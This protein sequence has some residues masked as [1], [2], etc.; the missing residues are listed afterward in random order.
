[1]KNKILRITLLLT[2]ILTCFLNS[3]FTQTNS[4]NTLNNQTE[5][6]KQEIKQHLTHIV[7]SYIHK[8]APKS[9]VNGKTIVNT[10]LD[11][12]VDIK[13]V[14]AQGH[15]ESHFGTTGVA[16]KT[17]NIFNVGAESK[18]PIKKMA[19]NGYIYK[20]PDESVEPFI[21]LLK[22]NYLV[23]GKTEE[24]LLKNYVNRSG[25]RYASSRSYESKLRSIVNNLKKT[26]ITSYT[27]K[28][29]QCEKIK[30]ILE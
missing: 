4:L 18:F 10:C 22:R 5:Q 9:K 29:K 27:N 1:M 30:Y 16:A 12:D 24:D 2:F 20:H 21:K 11:Y 14:L 8:T 13:L 15:I 7:D 6:R 25:H 3:S 17:N 23:N 26:Q 28:Y 19:R